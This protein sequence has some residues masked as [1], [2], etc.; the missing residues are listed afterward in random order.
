[1][2]VISHSAVNI[3]FDSSQVTFCIKEPKKKSKLGNLSTKVN[4]YGGIKCSLRK[5]VSWNL[6]FRQPNIR[7]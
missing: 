5:A 1:M 2:K 4:V 6:S 3:L 7:M